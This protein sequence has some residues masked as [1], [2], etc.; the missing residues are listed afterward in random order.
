MRKVITYGTFDLF[1]QGHYNILKR[2]KALGDYLVVGVTSESYDIERGKLSV[3]DDLST[4]M[5]N[6]KDTGFADEIIIEEY[7]GQKIRDIQKYQIDVFVIGSDWYGKFENLKKYC[8]VVY[9]ERTKNISSTIIR[10]QN[11][12][13]KIGIATDD[14]DDGQFVAEAQFV[15]GY[16]VQSVYSPN[17]RTASEFCAKY[18]LAEYSSDFEKFLEGVQLVY[19]KTSLQSRYELIKKAIS[20]GV[21]IIADSPVSDTQERMKELFELARSKNVLLFENLRTAYLRG[22]SQLAW[23]IQSNHIIGDIYHIHCTASSGAQSRQ[24]ISYALYMIFKLMGYDYLSIKE[25][26][27]HGENTGNTSY[28][29]ITVKYPQALADIEIYNHS[30]L[31][32]K[33][34]II[35][36]SGCVVIPDDWWNT[37]FYKHITNEGDLN[38]SS[39]NFE[40]NGLRYILQEMSITIRNGL[41]DNPRLSVEESLAIQKAMSRREKL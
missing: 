22:F 13:M 27:S 38:R 29:Y 3:R 41:Y 25:E 16:H 23:M 10:E 26:L 20:H 32:E 5:K 36:S 7:Q 24:M 4:R 14:A 31:E 34:E 30:K 9:L 39:F 21:N 12:S 6:V 11:N 40:G 35:G 1:H 18:G 33:M 2:A 28:E 15:S 17:E 8:E 37:R 19:I